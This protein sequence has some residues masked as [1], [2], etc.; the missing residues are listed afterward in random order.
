MLLATISYI[1]VCTASGLSESMKVENPLEV[2][3]LPNML[4]TLHVT[5]KCQ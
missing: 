5:D 2:A 1:I 4:R 3:M